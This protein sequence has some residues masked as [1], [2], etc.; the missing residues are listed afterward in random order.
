V[1]LSTRAR[2]G[3]RA[4]L[5][6]AGHYKKRPLQ[7]KVI[8]HRQEISLKYLEQLMAILKS[9]GLVRSIRGPKGGY[10][11]AKAPQQIKLS[12]VFNCL[13]G[14]L[15]AAECVENKSLCTRAA[16][17]VTRQLWSQ[18]QQAVKDVLES[19]TLQDLLDRSKNNK[20]VDYQI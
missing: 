15:V 9:A 20:T 2:Y 7:I 1:K 10:G 17:C 3:T 12:E 4:I 13:E 18:V 19:M 6:L 14:P 16:D 5:E 11:L 8:A